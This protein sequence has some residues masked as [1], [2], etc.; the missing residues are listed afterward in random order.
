MVF[1][2]WRNEPL[3]LGGSNHFMVN[4]A[5]ISCKEHARKVGKR[6]ADPREDRG[7]RQEA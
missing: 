7:A 3:C 5:L 6:A 2:M 4:S 1:K